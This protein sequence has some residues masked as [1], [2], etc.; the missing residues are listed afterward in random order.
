MNEDLWDTEGRQ[1]FEK[2]NAYGPDSFGLTHHQE[3]LGID[4][5]LKVGNQFKSDAERAAIRAQEE[6]ERLRL[7][8]LQQAND[9]ARAGRY[10]AEAGARA[11]V[12]ALTGVAIA[13]SEVK[14]RLPQNLNIFSADNPMSDT[15]SFV[16]AAMKEADIE[17][18]H[19]VAA[20]TYSAAM[21]LGIKGK[22]SGAPPSPRVVKVVK[23]DEARG[24]TEEYVMREAKAL[25]TMQSTDA[26]SKFSHVEDYFVKGDFFF[27]ALEFYQG[28]S[29]S[30]HL[31]QQ[32]LAL[33]RRRYQLDCGL[34]P[35]RVQF[36]AAEILVAIEAM[37]QKGIVHRD[38]KPA[39]ILLDMMGHVKVTDFGVSTQHGGRRPLNI[40]KM[41]DS[42]CR[43]SSTMVGTL[44]YMA[45][46]VLCGSPYGKS[47]D[48]WSYGATLHELMTG[49]T[50]YYLYTKEP[51]FLKGELCDLEKS[52][53]LHLD[54]FGVAFE[55]LI[56]GLLKKDVDQRLGSAALGDREIKNHPF[57]EGVDF[58]SLLGKKNAD[59]VDAPWLPEVEDEFD[60]RYMSQRVIHQDW[61]LPFADVEDTN[62]FAMAESAR[63][64]LDPLGLDLLTEADGITLALLAL[65]HDRHKE[66]VFFE[67]VLRAMGLA[68][69]ME[70]FA[71]ASYRAYRVRS[72]LELLPPELDQI[73]TQIQYGVGGCGLLVALVMLAR[74]RGRVGRAN[75]RAQQLAAHGLEHD[76]QDP[77]DPYVEDGRFICHFGY[78]DSRKQ[79]VAS[80]VMRVV[81]P[82]WRVIRHGGLMGYL[83]GSRAADHSKHLA[84]NTWELFLDILGSLT[85]E[86]WTE[87][88]LWTSC[89]LVALDQ[90]LSM[91]LIPRER[92][93]VLALGLATCTVLFRQFCAYL[94][95]PKVDDESPSEFNSLEDEEAPKDEPVWW[96]PSV[97]TL[98]FTVPTLFGGDGESAVGAE[99][100]VEVEAAGRDTG[101]A[102]RGTEKEEKMDDNELQGQK[103][104][105][106]QPVVPPLTGFEKKTGLLFSPEIVP[107]DA[108]EAFMTK[109][110]KAQKRAEEFRKRATLFGAVLGTQTVLFVVCALAA[111]AIVWFASSP[112]SV[113]RRDM[114]FLAIAFGTAVAWHKAPD[115]ARG[116]A[117]GA[118]SIMSLA[119]TAFVLFHCLARP[120]MFWEV[121]VNGV[122]L[123]G[124]QLV[125]SRMAHSAEPRLRAFDSA[126]LACVA[127]GVYLTVSA[128][129]KVGA[130][131]EVPSS[132]AAFGGAHVRLFGALHV[133]LGQACLTQ[134]PRTALIPVAMAVGFVSGV[135][136]P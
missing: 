53:P 134:S 116:L 63:K 117:I 127:F 86:Q 97:P 28:G 4:Y 75:E 119:R 124:A 85:L 91:Q 43:T 98:S 15:A 48:W 30:Y 72:G 114:L 77:F 81:A 50:P 60:T 64:R 79:T 19:M 118:V 58:K 5:A 54:H 32:R 136:T 120:L 13:A 130:S 131:L 65:R 68:C 11:G 45:P 132:M 10:A 112:E 108:T 92:A 125:Y 94:H 133:H 52:T 99:A 82:L 39:N 62:E 126:A 20:G 57:F 31:D 71:F 9:A 109:A 44:E 76:E 129:A 46:E 34:D 36:Y 93:P 59:P 89:A 107:D 104:Q 128:D 61:H 95:A 22:L 74:W 66:Y 40:S 113:G 33:G 121:M 96:M 27:M 12:D 26:Q 21:L 135:F 14:F 69:A 70:Y 16:E 6:A 41:N 115:T 18:H 84:T 37:H 102:N 56:I 47:A 7:E 111:N 17:V 29:L 123:I 23:I 67:N 103:Q 51:L 78:I 87:A 88:A 42:D 25:K 55:L 2:D 8:A 100:G 110:A 80:E 24:L 3:R 122:G 83:L 90:W 1:G 106:Q 38:L 35:V 49:A 101:E 73:V 105:E